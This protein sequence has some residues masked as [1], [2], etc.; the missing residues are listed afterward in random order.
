MK[1]IDKYNTILHNG[2]F[3][4]QA[5][6]HTTSF[7]IVTLSI[8]RSIII[9]INNYDNRLRSFNLIRLDLGESTA[10]AL[11]FI[12]GVEILKLFYINSYKQL[13]I[14]ICL[15]V[16]KLMISYFLLGEIAK[17]K[18]YDEIIK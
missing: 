5:L 2:I 17:I 15:V 12:L 18:K 4:V 11:S 7:I 14:V 1:F 6:S 13:I 16:I 10:L 9:Y 8:I 3:M